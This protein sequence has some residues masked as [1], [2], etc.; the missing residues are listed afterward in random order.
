MYVL[1]DLYGGSDNN[2]KWNNKNLYLIS[3]LLNQIPS[4]INAM[5]QSKAP[6]FFI[7]AK[8]LGR[9]FDYFEISHDRSLENYGTVWYDAIN[10]DEN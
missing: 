4:E 5:N 6:V 9:C 8:D 7:E 10:I 1:R 2:L 3:D